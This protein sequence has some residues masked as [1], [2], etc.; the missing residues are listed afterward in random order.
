MKRRA[1]IHTLASTGAAAS[2]SK[3]AGQSQAGDRVTIGL[4]GCGGRGMQLITDFA[5][6][7]DV[8]VKTVCDVDQSKF[9][10]AVSTVDEVGGYMPQKETDFRRMFD[11]PDI[12]A[13]VIAVNHHWHPL[14]TILACQAGKHVYVE[15]PMS[16]NIWEGWQMVKAA[17]KYNRVVQVGLQNRSFGYHEEAAEFIKS[18]KLGEI[19]SARLVN[20]AG[21]ASSGGKPKVIPVPD[22][23]D[24]DLFCGPGPMVPYR[25]QFSKRHLWDFSMGAI[26]DNAIHQTDVVRWVLGLDLPDSVTSTGGV[27]VNK[28]ERET[29]DTLVTAWKYDNLLLHLDASNATPYKHFI[30]LKPISFAEDAI[31]E[32]KLYSCPAYI[33][34]TEGMMILGRHGGGW[35][36]YGIDGSLI[37]EKPGKA[38]M[39]GHIGNFI[40]CIHSG[41][42]PNADVEKAQQ[43]HILGHMSNLSLRVG[44]VPLTWDH[45][46]RRFKNNDDANALLKRTY[47]KP[48]VV[49]DEV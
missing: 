30:W 38:D 21:R 8:R 14:A 4:M 47:R 9:D 2:V 1:F 39:P 15:K 13:V 33:M 26:W 23:L 11:D 46:N 37:A 7:P 17:R 16:Q 40:D 34:G 10:R 5:K 28:D 12:D 32:W 49:P 3:A 18:G 43:S 42:R 41:A 22:G 44:E 35:Q 25:R 45:A 20:H 36:A 29:P 6:R 24:Y 48:W 27:M 31:P 19:H